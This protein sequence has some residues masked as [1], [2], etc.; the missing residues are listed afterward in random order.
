M[1]RHFSH[2]LFYVKKG[3]KL[4]TDTEMQIILLFYSV[5]P[6]TM[7]MEMHKIHPRTKMTHITQLCLI[8]AQALRW[9]LLQ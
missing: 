4:Y 3:I 5:H 2:M 8:V 1:F 7:N 9:M 6:A